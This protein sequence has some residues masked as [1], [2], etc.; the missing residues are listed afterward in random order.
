M[1]KTEGCADRIEWGWHRKK[2][3]IGSHGVLDQSISAKA[4][5]VTTCVAYVLDGG[6]L[7]ADI[8]DRRCRTL[9]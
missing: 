9:D 6:T 7:D 1:T 4:R 2:F 3:V 5:P 8:A